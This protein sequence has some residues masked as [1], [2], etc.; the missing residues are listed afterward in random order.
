MGLKRGNAGREGGDVK[1][2]SRV[3]TRAE[4]KTWERLTKALEGSRSLVE[5]GNAKGTARS[6]DPTK[7]PA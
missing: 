3:G 5:T 2:P 7:K 4:R 1:R 6:R